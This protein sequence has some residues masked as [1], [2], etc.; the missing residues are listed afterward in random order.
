MNFVVTARGHLSA[1]QFSLTISL[2]YTFLLSEKCKVGMRRQRLYMLSVWGKLQILPCY[3][4]LHIA[5]LVHELYI[6]VA[7]GHTE[8]AWYMHMSMPFCFYFHFFHKTT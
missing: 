4:E 6:L 3:I 8:I 5:F 1:L 2:N 7:R